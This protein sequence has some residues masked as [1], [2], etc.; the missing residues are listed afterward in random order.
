MEVKKLKNRRSRTFQIRKNLNLKAFHFGGKIQNQR[1]ETLIALQ[2]ES[3]WKK[4]A[5]AESQEI[6]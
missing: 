3:F 6:Y 4:I 1:F 5:F 2:I